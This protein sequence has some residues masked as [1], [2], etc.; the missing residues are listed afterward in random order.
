MIKAVLFDCGGVLAYP[1]AGYWP[2][3]V[4]LDSILGGRKLNIDRA[5]ADAA[6]KE[7]GGILDEGRLITGLGHELNL[8]RLFLKKM[9]E[10]LEAGLSERET[11]LIARSLTY[12]DARY[13]L[14][15]DTK[16][17]LNVFADNYKIGFL[18]NA[19]PSMVRALTNHG[20]TD[21]L[22][23]FTVS[24]LEGCQKPEEKI[25]RLALGE[26]GLEP[27]E[28]VFIEDVEANLLAAK[29][30]GIHAVRMARP[31]YYIEPVPD[32]DWDGPV[33]HDLSEAF[34]IVNRLRG[35]TA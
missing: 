14:Y 4:E 6:M 28:C 8:R 20:I 23:C 11:D 21:R 33:A 16:R 2:R 5:K 1:G 10:A 15:D 26:L 9:N 22:S 30:I 13:A 29:R 32:F 3:S 7:F 35:E 12:N 25:Y 17:M 27:D 24:C 18:S 19:M 34:V 31:F